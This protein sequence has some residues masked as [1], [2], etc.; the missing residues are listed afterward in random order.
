M[1][2][3]DRAVAYRS[4]KKVFTYQDYLDLP[5]DGNRYEVINGELIMVAA[6][7]TSHLRI[8]RK[9]L[10]ELLKHVEQKEL[11]EV[12]YA[13]FDVVL[14]VSIVVQP[15][16]FFVSKEN[17]KIVTERNISGSPDMVIEIISPSTAYYDLLE[18]KELYAT[19]GVKEYW[20][21]EPKKE[22]IEVYLNK[23]GKFELDQRV[24]QTGIVRSIIVKNWTLNLEK[25]FNF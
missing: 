12:F 11:G 17:S 5:E 4:Q 7:N 21:V 14:S 6:P 19:H 10:S 24:E 15:D 9:I 23:N 18:K 22:W 3:K 1:E 13:P 2:I 8:G 20:I 25:V 16:I